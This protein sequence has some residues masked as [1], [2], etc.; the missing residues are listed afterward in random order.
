MG[1]F[2]EKMIGG[3]PPRKGGRKKTCTAQVVTGE[4]FPDLSEALN[5]V[6]FYAMNRPH[7]DG[8]GGVREVGEKCA[9]MMPGVEVMMVNPKTGQHE[10]AMIGD[11]VVS[12]ERIK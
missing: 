8:G 5:V 2:V 3:Q 4:E 1:D 7:N 9:I 6:M 12:I 11:Y 10:V